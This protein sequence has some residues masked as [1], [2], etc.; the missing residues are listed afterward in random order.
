MDNLIS[1]LLHISDLPPKKRQS[2]LDL[3]LNLSP[4]VS[5]CQ[6]LYHPQ[7]CSP[8]YGAMAQVS[9]PL[10]LQ[11]IGTTS[12]ALPCPAHLIE[13]GLFCVKKPAYTTSTYP[14][15]SACL[16]ATTQTQEDTQ[17]DGLD[18]VHYGDRFWT[19]ECLPGFRRHDG[20]IC[21]MRCPLGWGDRGAK[22][23]KAGNLSLGAPSLWMPGDGREAG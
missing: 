13:D 8:L 21:M 16:N 23:E 14:S 3:R 17:G 10:G 7:P 22:C 19:R 9:C 15:Q 1:K 4:A 18:C 12:C 5:R 11:R 20:D 6:S 2:I